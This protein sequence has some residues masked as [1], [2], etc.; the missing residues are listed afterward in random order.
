MSCRITLFYRP[1]VLA[2]G[3]WNHGSLDYEHV[4]ANQ[5]L[6]I[7]NAASIRFKHVSFSY[8]GKRDV[9]QDIS[10]SIKKARRCLCGLGSTGSGKSSIINL[11]HRF[12]SLSGGG[13][14]LMMLILKTIVGGGATTE[15]P[16]FC[17]DPFLYHGTVAVFSLHKESGQREKTS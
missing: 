16:C 1:L 14:W 10:F 3:F 2:D 11:F 15:W 13:F 4:R 8:D 5:D 12:M 17:E 9:L 7:Q 6:Q